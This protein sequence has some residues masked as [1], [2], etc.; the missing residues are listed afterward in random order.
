MNNILDFVEFSLD[1]FHLHERMKH[2]SFV[3]NLKDKLG[4]CEAWFWKYFTN[5]AKY[6]ISQ[7]LNSIFIP[8]SNSFLELAFRFYWYMARYNLELYPY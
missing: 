4:F 8:Y 7:S 2:L 1:L 6:A 3:W 5:Y